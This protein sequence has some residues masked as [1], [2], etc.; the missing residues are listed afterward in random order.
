MTAQLVPPIHEEVPFQENEL[1]ISQADINGALIYCN[2]VYCRA[3]EVTTAEAIGQTIHFTWHPDMPRSL[4]KRIMDSDPN[5]AELFIYIKHI[6]KSGKYFWALAQV[7]PLYDQQNTH[8]GF[9]SV[10]RHVKREVSDQIADLYRSIYSE[11]QR[12]ADPDAA[13]MAGEALLNTMLVD[14]GKDYPKFIWSTL[15]EQP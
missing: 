15:G 7:S 8:I 1:M 12:H 2:D 5:A 10:R 14:Q 6:S 3:M 13:I 9:N 11:E 4:F